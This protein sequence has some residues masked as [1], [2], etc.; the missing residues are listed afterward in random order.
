[1]P[2]QSGLKAI[3]TGCPGE[4]PGSRASCNSMARHEA[5]ALAP[6]IGVPGLFFIFCPGQIW[7]EL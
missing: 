7:F 2:A 6:M 4:R 3:A 5:E 1:M